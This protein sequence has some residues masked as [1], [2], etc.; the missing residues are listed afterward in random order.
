MPPPRPLRTSDCDTQ[1]TH[2]EADFKKASEVVVSSLF[3]AFGNLSFLD[4]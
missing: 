3:I 2:P 1:T 4:P